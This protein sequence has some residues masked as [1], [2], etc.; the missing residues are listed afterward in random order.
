[1][2]LSFKSFNFNMPSLNTLSN[3]F[4]RD[5]IGNLA[6]R[7]LPTALAGR[8]RAVAVVAIAILGAVA[9]VVGVLISRRFTMKKGAP[10]AGASSTG[11]EGAAKTPESASSTASVTAATQS[12]ADAALLGTSTTSAGSAS[13]Q[14]ESGH[15]S[16]ANSDTSSSDED[17]VINANDAENDE[18]HVE[19]AA[20]ASTLP[21]AK[22]PLLFAT[23]KSSSAGSAA[24]TE[25]STHVLVA[26]ANE[27][28]D[29][30]VST[31]INRTFLEDN[32]DATV[33][34]SVGGKSI[35]D[36]SADDSFLVGRQSAEIDGDEPS[37][38]SADPLN[39]STASD[40]DK[41]ER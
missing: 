2:N 34:T 31:D 40:Y 16:E 17:S 8:E 36:E 33:D 32:L 24:A 38:D 25:D 15:V 9:C 14:D 29:S 6:K 7:Y 11:A 18:D 41:F 28:R 10:E 35:L 20:Y 1:M 5:N 22:T 39:L 19:D 30:D 27:D 13:S 23:P 12:V 4:T 3:V 21:V 26:D 37:N